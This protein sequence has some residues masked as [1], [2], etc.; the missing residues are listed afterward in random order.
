MTRSNLHRQAT[1]VRGY[2]PASGTW[3]RLGSTAA[4]RC[5]AACCLLAVGPARRGVL[6]C[7]GYLS[8]GTFVRTAEIFSLCR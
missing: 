1:T 3:R 2:H 6:S 8:G 5:N 4:A 7:G